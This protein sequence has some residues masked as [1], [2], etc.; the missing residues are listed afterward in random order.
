[1]DTL[2]FEQKIIGF[3][4]LSENCF[5]VVDKYF[6]VNASHYRDSKP[7]ALKRYDFNSS[8]DSSVILSRFLV[9]WNKVSEILFFR[10]C[11]RLLNSFAILL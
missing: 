5:F 6:R 1:M 9:D 4:L 3:E 7:S 2:K 10:L 11:I 8:N